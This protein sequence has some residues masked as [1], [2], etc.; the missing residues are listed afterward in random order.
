MVFICLASYDGESV[1]VCV[2]PLYLF[3]V[4]RSGN[5]VQLWPETILVL[6]KTDRERGA[7]YQGFAQLGLLK[8]GATLSIRH[9]EESRY[10]GK[11]S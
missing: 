3:P 6:F 11:Q 10:Q 1:C 8:P 2:L 7:H 9:Y 5:M 4:S